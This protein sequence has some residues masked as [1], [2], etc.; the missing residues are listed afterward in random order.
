MMQETKTDKLKTHDDR[1]HSNYEFG[2]I[3][4]PEEQDDED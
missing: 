1:Q 3:S 4:E 2:E